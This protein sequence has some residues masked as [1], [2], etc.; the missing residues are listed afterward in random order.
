[1]AK[2]MFAQ[3]MFFPLQSTQALSAYLKRAGHETDLAIGSPEEIVSYARNTKPDLIGFSVLTAYRNHMLA[4]TSAIK[5]AD[6]TA[7]VIA[8][9]Y[10]IT[11]MPQILENSDLDIICI[12]EGG[13]PITELSDALDAGR[14]FRDLT[15]GNLHIKK[16]DGSIHKEPMRYWSMSLDDAPFDD[17]DIYL[18][19]DSYFSIIPFT[20]VLAGRGCPYPC[21]YCF[22]DGYKKIHLEEGMKNSEYT[23]F[24]SVDHVIS[25]LKM[26]S[27]KYKVKDFFFNDSTLTYNKDWILEFCRKYKE[28]GLK[29]SFSI[30]SVIPELSEEVCEA[31]ADTGCCRLIR[32]GLETG[33]EEFRM[34]TLRK[35]VRNTKMIE[36][37]D[38]MNRYGLRYSMQ[39]MLGLPGETINFAWES[40]DF[41]RQITGPTGVHGINIFK[42]FPGLEINNVGLELG[43]YQAS[44]VVA[45]GS[46]PPPTWR[47]ES[48]EKVSD[49]GGKPILPADE[50]Y[51]A[52]RANMHSS[53]NTATLELPDEIETSED[54]HSEGKSH[55]GDI[56]MV[57]FDNY[58]R[59]AL[60]LKILKL[61]RYSH[62]AIR[63]PGLKPIIN[64]II[65]LPD[66][67][68]NRVVWTITEGLLNIRVHA[69]APWSYFFKY[70][71]FHRDKKVR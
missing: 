62:L 63:F 29:Q 61:S 27:D 31:L 69:G 40:I 47:K 11:F 54:F 67:A 35:S 41:A 10:D 1:M 4:T 2:I 7:P 39:M 9:G 57:F 3:E 22:N 37:T 20:Q 43:E 30:N 56:E 5:E 33:N 12:G 14:D 8:G 60:G 21:T 18:D 17:R 32:F 66:N 15:I 55:F 28:A 70:F 59:D 19:K 26:L 49:S 42:P 23:T 46:V 45:P 24:R 64:K 51:L 58:R 36:V 53:G 65:E 25:E 71:L 48:F 68:F 13:D 34:K 52:S 38:R 44:D 6:I 50:G 16:A